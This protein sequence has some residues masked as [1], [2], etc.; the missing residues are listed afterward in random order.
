MAIHMIEMII[1]ICLCAT[2]VHAIV[3]Y[4]RNGASLDELVA[5]YFSLLYTQN[6]ILGF[7]LFV[8]NVMLRKRTLKRILR[9]L[10]LRRRG[11]ENPL[12]DIGS[13]II[14]LRRFGYDQVGYRTMWRLLNTFCGVHATQETV[15]LTLTVIDTDGVNAR[16]R[17]RLIRRSKHSRGPNYCL[18]VDGYDKLKPFGISIHGCMDGFSRKIMWLT[19]VIPT[20]TH[21]TLLVTTSNI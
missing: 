12:V 6:E 7:L 19:P 16:R 13:K 17:R 10:N 5:Y 2:T 3:P 18:H 9:R 4:P 8:D 14:D 15:R 21:V 20:K 11:I 1:L